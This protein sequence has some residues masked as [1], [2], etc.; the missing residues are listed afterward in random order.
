M[1]KRKENHCE[2]YLI[3]INP[4]GHALTQE[5]APYA[6]VAMYTVQPV[7]Q[8]HNDCRNTGATQPRAIHTETISTAFRSAQITSP[9]LEHNS[10][11]QF[12]V[13]LKSLLRGW[14][15]AQWVQRSPLKNLSIPCKG[16]ADS[17]PLS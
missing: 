2:L 14:E 5:V 6:H 15:M 11:H 3:P 9:E 13:V 12:S 7:S 10:N 1:E 16:Q 17:Q 8:K 4:R